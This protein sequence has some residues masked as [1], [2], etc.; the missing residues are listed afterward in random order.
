MKGRG[1]TKAIQRGDDMRRSCLIMVVLVCAAA[2][3]SADIR[4]KSFGIGLIL[5]D[6]TGVSVKIWLNRG[7]ALDFG[8]GW[9]YYYHPR[10]YYPCE[11]PHYY[12]NNRAYCDAHYYNHG[13]HPYYEDNLHFH[14]DYLFH[15]FSLLKSSQTFG[16]Y[17]G[18]GFVLKQ[19]FDR[20][21]AGPRGNFG[22]A[23][24]PR[25]APLDVFFELAP[26][27]LFA[28]PSFELD[29]CLGVRF[30]L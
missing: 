5:P 28:D 20:L 10:Y 6:P 12:N 16:V 17:Y 23:W 15:N 8:L 30:W 7:N 14:A 21:Y 22:I 9:H 25:N 27:L 18:P 26:A 3:A 11:D 4:Q 24:L 19:L 2:V 29:G 13:Y 1:P